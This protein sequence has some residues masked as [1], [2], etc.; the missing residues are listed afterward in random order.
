MAEPAPRP[1]T[2]RRHARAVACTLALVMACTAGA[3][4]TEAEPEATTPT[5]TTPRTPLGN[6]RHVCARYDGER[7]AYTGPVAVLERSGDVG[8][9]EGE[10]AA[11][12]L[13]VVTMQEDTGRRAPQAEGEAVLT[14]EEAPDLLRRARTAQRQG[15]AI[16]EVYA[17]HATQEGH[18][19]R[20]T[21]ADGQR[22][23]RT[24]IVFTNA[25]LGIVESGAGRQGSVSDGPYR[26]ARATEPAAQPLLP[27]HCAQGRTG[28][29]D[30][31]GF[32]AP[33]TEVRLIQTALEGA[34][35]APGPIDGILGPRTLGALIRWNQQ[36][37]RRRAPILAYET[38]CRL[39]ETLGAEQRR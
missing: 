26:C 22:F 3:T 17:G 13:V 14:S 35:M 7:G 39:I 8:A 38:L 37:E 16:E 10:R 31:D 18:L 24:M 20:F 29:V 23:P 32:P 1:A 15:R 28:D 12:R 25:G 2:C 33:Q 27:D 34:G 9:A 36:T 11:Y 19:L 4:E 21:T 5:E 30:I 6:D